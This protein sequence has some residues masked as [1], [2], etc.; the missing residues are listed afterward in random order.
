MALIQ[1][2]E[3]DNATGQAK[4]IYDTMQELAGVIP[5]PLQLASASPNV[6]DAFWQSIQYYVYVFRLQSG[7]L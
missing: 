5:A 4:K 1:L 7:F 3:P 2:V 6:L